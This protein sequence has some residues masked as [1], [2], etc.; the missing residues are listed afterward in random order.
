MWKPHE[1]L[2]NG[3]KRNNKIITR[4]NVKGQNRLGKYS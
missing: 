1:V 3:R 4:N 2:I